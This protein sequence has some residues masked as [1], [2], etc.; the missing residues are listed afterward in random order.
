MP[1]APIFHSLLA[2]IVFLL[3][4]GLPGIFLQS[5]IATTTTSDTI[6]AVEVQL[7]NIDFDFGPHASQK[8]QRKA[9]V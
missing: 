3:S 1:F 2:F 5:A 4:A 8:Q 7:D 9:L 6:I